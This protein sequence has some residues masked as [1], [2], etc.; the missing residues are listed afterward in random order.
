MWSQ[1]SFW[2][3]EIFRFIAGVPAKVGTGSPGL[4]VGVDLV[5][6]VALSDSLLCFSGLVR[7]LFHLLSVRDKLV[8][9]ASGATL[10]DPVECRKWR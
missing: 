5:V 3:V 6:V 4:R 2:I 7:R 10:S 1:C 8:Y 9:A